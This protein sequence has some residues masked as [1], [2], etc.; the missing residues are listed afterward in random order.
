MM[1]K[2]CSACGTPTDDIELSQEHKLCADCHR[3][4]EQ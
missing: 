1:L 3:N 4:Y 2:P